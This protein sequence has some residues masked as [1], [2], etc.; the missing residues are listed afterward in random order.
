MTEGYTAQNITVLEGLEGVKARPSM[1]IGDTS[2]RGLHQLV[3]EAVANS[4]DEAQ[5][6]YCKNISVV[7]HIDGSITIEDD[8]RGIPIDEHPTE[9]RPAVEVVLTKLHAGGKFDKKSYK[10][11]GGLH[12]VGISVTNALSEWLNVEVVRD[13]RVYRQIYENGV[14]KTPVIETGASD[15]TGTKIRFLPN[16]SIFTTTEFHYDILAKRLRELTFLN[17]GLRIKIKDERTNVETEFYYEG[18]LISFVE[19][20]NKNK[21]TL[22]GPIYL[23]KEK[24]GIF[25]ELAMQYND[26][27]REDIFSF[28]NSINTV[29]GGTHV[30]GF[31]SALTRVINNYQKKNNMNGMALSGED[32]REGLCAIMSVKVPEPQFEGQTK[33]KLG[34][35]EIK[36]IVDSIV[37]EKLSEYFD[38]NPAI[39]KTIIG[40]CISAANAREAARKARELTRRKGI[41]VSGG[42]PGKL[43]DCQ[44]KDPVKAELFI[45]EGDSAG[46]SARAGRMREFQ[47]ILPLRG[48][49]LNVEKARLDKIF[50]NKEITNIITAIGA[51]IGDDFDVNKVRYNKIILM[52]DSDFDGE[53]ICTLL[54]TFFYRYMK[55][56]IEKGYLYIAN[57]PLYK[58]VKNKKIS[59]VYNDEQLNILL[60]EIGKEGVSLQR[61]KGLGEMNSDQLFDTTMDPNVR[62]LKR[63]TIEDA[64]KAD[65][66]FSILMGELVEPR[67]EFISKYAKEV[68][69]LDI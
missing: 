7:I 47:A 64:V 46:G 68:K 16:K 29:E 66:I 4:V 22:S 21:N 8:G 43:A 49:V 34:N 23:S 24:N 61:Y 26:G 50:A 56:L 48:K 51:G 31:Y 15:R 45:V 53:H 17:K 44:E 67:R 37:F 30:S 28:V 12:G 52:S 10:V 42:L 33:S 40:K 20:L 59:Y 13:S 32:V 18:G 19:F 57:A 63:V 25:V 62:K 55:P 5:I 14:P 11:S 1:Y 35:S 9:K 6:G 58:I 60:N 27:Y 2:I 41:L 36:G 38:K 39:A 54:L 69:N 65:E 3:Y